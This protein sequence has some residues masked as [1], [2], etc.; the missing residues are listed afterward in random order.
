LTLCSLLAHIFK[1]LSVHFEWL[2][3][4]VHGADFFRRWHRQKVNSGGL[5]V[6]KSGHHFDL[7]NWWLDAQPVTVAGFGNLGFYGDE[8]GKRNGWA[9]DYERARG[10]EV[11]KSD[12]FAIDLEADDTMKSIYAD[13]EKEDGY[14]R[15]QNVSMNYLIS[16]HLQNGR[17]GVR[18]WYWYR[19]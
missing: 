19:G 1:V 2:L 12:P 5:M 15:D 6:H 10:S 14:H 7:V 16:A 17:I 13:A 8:N 18:P 3:D 11:A 9:K 4:T